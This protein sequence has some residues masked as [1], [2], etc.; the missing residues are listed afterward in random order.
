MDK[1]KKSTKEVFDHHLK[2]YSSKD[3]IGVME[4]FSNSAIYISST[5][6]IAKGKAEIQKVYEDYFK[7]LDPRNNFS[8]KE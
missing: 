3:I 4:D 6:I 5:G 7:S 2:A 1:L 8:N